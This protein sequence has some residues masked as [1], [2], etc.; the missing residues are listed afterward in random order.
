MSIKKLFYLI[1]FIFLLLIGAFFI[2]LYFFSSSSNP[3]VT[4]L[5]EKKEKITFQKKPSPKVLGTFTSTPFNSVK[6]PLVNNF[7]NNDTKEQEEQKEDSKEVKKDKEED[8]NKDTSKDNSSDSDN[9]KSDT[10]EDESIQEVSKVLENLNSFISLDSSANN[11]QDQA[12]LVFA[13]DLV[14]FFGSE[15]L[16][17]IF[18]DVDSLS[19]SNLKKI[20]DDEY[21]AEVS[22]FSQGKE[23][24]HLVYLFKFDAGW[25]IY[26]TSPL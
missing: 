5:P 13:P 7:S 15:S 11:L 20:S 14:E 16:L 8:K 25:R 9:P 10:S 21:S 17:N 19:Y 1:L 24:K 26:D 2:K 22:L 12:L 3:K 18:S 4:K 23:E 6:E